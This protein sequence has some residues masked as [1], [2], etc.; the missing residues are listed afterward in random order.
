MSDKKEIVVDAVVEETT[1]GAI[2][3]A[4]RT[5]TNSTGQE[6]VTYG[7][8]GEVLSC[9]FARVDFNVPAT[10]LSYCD[11]VKNEISA[12]LDSTAQMALDSQEVQVDDKM[13][14]NITSFEE[15]LDESEKQ[16]QKEA[17][18]PAIIKGI[19]GILATLGVKR[20]EENQKKKQLIKVV[21]KNTVKD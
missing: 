9:Q 2:V 18:Q 21:M 3:P 4:T 19:K 14:A 15:S 1:T 20:F 16:K 12:I 6:I 17:N 5:V 8:K 10:I 11:D 7:E 13:I